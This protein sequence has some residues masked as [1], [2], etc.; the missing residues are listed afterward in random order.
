MDANGKKVEKPVDKA[1][2]SG[3]KV[4]PY[5]GAVKGAE[6]FHVPPRK[7][8]AHFVEGLRLKQDN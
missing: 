3:F 8:T 5:R 4:I 7:L 2:V 6:A 1:K